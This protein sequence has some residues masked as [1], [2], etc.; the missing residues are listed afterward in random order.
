MVRE[1]KKRGV[2]V[3]AETC[4]HYFTLTDEAVRGYNTMAKMNPPL[5]TAEDVAAIR[6]G[7]KD[8]TIDVI[9][10][11]HA[12]HGMDEKSGEFDNVPFGIVGLETALGLTLKLV[13]EGMLS[14][15]EAI[16]KLSLNP[17]S[18][19][20]LNKGSLSIGADA[21]ITIIDPN[22]AWTVDSTLFKSKSRNTPFNKW[23]L[24]GRAEQTIVGGKL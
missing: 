18:I 22:I 8:G 16:R 1:A 21:D 9:A 3:T 12:P 7:L 10:T 20:K 14:M 19:L 17:A 11:D 24:R 6:Q 4:P 23:Q 13:Q 15:T 2:K 5:R